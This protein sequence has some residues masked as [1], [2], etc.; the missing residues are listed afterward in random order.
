MEGVEDWVRLVSSLDPRLCNLL[1]SGVLFGFQVA[2]ERSSLPNFEVLFLRADRLGLELEHF[3]LQRAFL[4]DHLQSLSVL[5][6]MQ[7][8]FPGLGF[9]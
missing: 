4:F 9:S 1:Y 3:F 5:W 6:R 8:G 2:G 7:L